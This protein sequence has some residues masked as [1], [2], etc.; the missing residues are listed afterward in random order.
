MRRGRILVA[1]MLALL[2]AAIG[3]GGY[4]GYFGGPVF[5][6]LPATARPAPGRERLA[7]VV[8]SGDLG[9]RIGMAPRIAAGLAAEGISTVGV[10]TLTYFR[11][12]RSRAEV[13]ALIDKATRRAL[14]M[15]QADKI[16]L[17]GQSFGADMLHVGLTGMAP[18]LRA[19]VRMVALVVPTDSVIYRAS[20][21][22]LFDWANGD[23]GEPA[24]ATARRLDWVPLLCI[25][26]VE[27][28]GSLCPLLRGQA[29]VRVTGLP[30]G[31]P[32]HGD[33]GAVLRVI[34]AAI[35]TDPQGPSRVAAP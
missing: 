30:G 2:A 5:T 8:L 14:A 12:R 17:I 28:R 33:A 31:H 18:A 22:E 7:A 6:D 11:H 27:E 24:I 20:P 35:D 10:N 25:H 13:E 26:G 1:A 23:P 4:I 29:N 15:G 21:S 16:V 9:F 32:L 3:F 34:D 19:R